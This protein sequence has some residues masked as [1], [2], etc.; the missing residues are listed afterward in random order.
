M[1]PQ[2]G[3][4]EGV[5]RILVIDDDAAARLLVRTLA[6][7][8]GHDVIEAANGAQGLASA[9]ASPPDLI[10]VDLSLPQMSGTE[11]IRALRREPRT[12]AT[13]IALY[14]ATTRTAAIDDFMQMY[15]LSGMLPKPGEPAALLAAIAGALAAP[16]PVTDLG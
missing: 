1:L 7:Y 10:V 11:V 6:E 5:A 13:R 9:H 2:S 16:L 15:G 12:R 4:D 3:A 14:T 8:A